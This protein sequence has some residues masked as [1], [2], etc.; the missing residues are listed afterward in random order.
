MLHRRKEDTESLEEHLSFDRG[1]EPE[2]GTRILGLW[3][4]WIFWKHNEKAHLLTGNYL[5]F[6]GLLVIIERRGCAR[7]ITEIPRIRISKIHK[8]YLVVFIVQI[9]K[10]PSIS[11]VI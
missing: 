10:D 11:S 3:N 9:R 1:N 2:N 8:V 5:S 4:V 6:I 7:E